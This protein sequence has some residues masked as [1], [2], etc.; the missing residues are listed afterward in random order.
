MADKKQKTEKTVSVRQPGTKRQTIPVP[1]GDIFGQ[2]F[3]PSLWGGLYNDQA[4]WA[5]AIN[6]VEKE[7]KFV[8]K[9]ELPGVQEEDVNVV[10]MGDV[11]VIEGEKEAESE[12]KKKGYA[13]SETSYGSFSRSISIPSIVDADKIS[14]NFDKG[15][16]EI[17]LP[18]SVEVK[19]K[20]VSVT[21]TKKTKTNNN[22]TSDK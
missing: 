17:D 2:P 6:V 16:L 18:K 15:V 11:L 20:K 12:V 14:A 22:K 3:L 5:P 1:S 21:T 8:A 19:P 7:D 10:V 4:F 9:V 13:Y